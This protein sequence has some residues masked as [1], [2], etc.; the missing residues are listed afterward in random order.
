MSP[1]IAGIIVN[2]VPYHHARWEA[3]AR[4][5]EAEVHLVEL[6]SRDDFKVLEFSQ[7]STYHRH[8][9]LD[10]SE[11]K[12]IPTSQLIR[13]MAAK[14]DQI[15]PEVICVSGWGLTVSLAAMR[16]ASL[17]RIP[18]VMLSE[19]NEF[20]EVRS[21]LKEWVK[22]RLLGLSSA[23]LAGGSPQADYLVKLGLPRESVFVGYD[24]V[25][26]DFFGN[27]VKEIKD[28]E[29]RFQKSGDFDYTKRYF[30]ACARFGKKKNMPGLIRAFSKYRKMAL[31]KS[32]LEILD[33]DF[34]SQVSSFASSP[35]DLVIAGEGEERLGIEEAIRVNHLERFVHLVGAKSFSELPA[36]YALSV[37]FIHASTTEQWGL[38]VNE[39]MASGAP[40][41]VSNR[42]GC[43]RDLVRDGENGY[44][45]DPQNEE[46]LSEL[47]VKISHDEN[48]RLRM[49][50][51]SREI[52]ANWG[53]QRFVSGLT[54]AIH[55]ALRQKNRRHNFLGKLVLNLM[56][57]HR[58]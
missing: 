16:W 10:D 32:G 46:E 38:V 27:R 56:L 13:R 11:D 35:C 49:G 50:G 41:L 29:I 57:S 6:T 24:V 22:R 19:S 44:T 7:S 28:L 15:Q 45:F 55:T 9:L 3:I 37:A 26:N 20:D 30:F 39:A 31:M 47:M 52:I 21:V 58:N 12:N 23:G 53:P 51:K 33:S 14:L 40:V 42:C 34:N 54:C 48:E 18:I 1:R 4:C 2:M 36:Y 25:D 43:A 5:W 8:A 17:N